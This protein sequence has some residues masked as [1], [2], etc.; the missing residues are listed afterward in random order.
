[1]KK[2]KEKKERNELVE[3]S[4]ACEGEGEENGEDDEAMHSL[5]LWRETERERE[6]DSGFAF[7]VCFRMCC[8][9]C[10]WECG[11]QRVCF[12]GASGWRER[13]W[14]VFV[15]IIYEE[16]VLRETRWWE[17]WKRKWDPLSVSDI[18][19]WTSDYRTTIHHSCPGGQLACCLMM[20]MKFKNCRHPR[21]AHQTEP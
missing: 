10:F 19:K 5:L 15:S 13:E 20:Q 16:R 9:G 4:I 3:V 11:V 7:C 14:G 6:R 12:C 2:M 21:L 17:G 8:W 1:M 18:N